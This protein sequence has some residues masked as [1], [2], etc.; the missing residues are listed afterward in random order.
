MWTRSLSRKLATIR[1][2]RSPARRAGL[3]STTNFERA[4]TL[5]PHDCDYVALADQ[6]DAWYRDKLAALVHSVGAAQ[7]VYCDAPIIGP[8]GETIAD[9]YRERRANNYTEPISLLI[10]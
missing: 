7:L 4:L 5:T 8:D 9:S 3:A 10:R 1:G 6:D 2:S